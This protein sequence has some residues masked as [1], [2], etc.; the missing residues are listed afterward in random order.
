MPPKTVEMASL[1]DSIKTIRKQLHLSQ[2]EMAR[3]LGVTVTTLSRWANDRTREPDPSHRDRL[4]ALLAVVEEAN[5]AIK[6]K[7]IVWWFRAP[8]PYLSDLSPMDLLHSA[9]GLA[10]VK[11]ILGSMRW[12]LT[13]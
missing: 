12:G 3:L 8:H 7:G 4:N 11:T 1:H 6:P 9:T 13:A 5:E 2:E 10:K